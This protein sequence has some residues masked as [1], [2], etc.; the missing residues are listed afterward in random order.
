MAASSIPRVL[1]TGGSGYIALHIVRQLLEAGW[2]VR[3][4][5]RDPANEVKTEPLRSLPGA[6]ER[7]ELVKADLLQP[8]DKWGPVVAGCD[9]VLHTASP[10][11]LESPKNRSEVI[12]PAV[13]GK[14]QYQKFNSVGARGVWAQLIPC[15]T[16]VPI[17]SAISRLQAQRQF[18]K[19]VLRTRGSSA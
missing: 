19:P 5:V 12:L 8:E 1:V 6:S 18:S 4:T 3:A 13:N 14:P 16:L 10:F 11:P 7:L 15:T 17:L 9:Y 2:N